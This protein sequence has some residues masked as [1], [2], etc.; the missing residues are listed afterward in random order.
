MVYEGVFH[1]FI[2]SLPFAIEA[3]SCKFILDSLYGAYALA[4]EFNHIT[5]GILL[6][7][8]TDNLS[9]FYPLFILGLGETCRSS[10]LPPF[11]IY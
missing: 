1:G 8:E 5:D 4:G 9:I 3:T 11:K 6:V 10:S 2:L 7:Q